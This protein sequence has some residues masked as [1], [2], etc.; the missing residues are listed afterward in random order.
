MFLDLGPEL[1]LGICVHEIG[2]DSGVTLPTI[3]YVL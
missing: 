3:C 2:M 1:K